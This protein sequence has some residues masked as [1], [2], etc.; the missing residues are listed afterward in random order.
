VRQTRKRRGG[1][2]VETIFWLGVALRLALTVVNREANDPHVEVSRIIADE[3]RV[4]EIGEVWEAFQPKLYHLLVAGAWWVLSLRSSSA[5]IVAAQMVSCVAGIVVLVVVRR[6]L[7]EIDIGT[8]ARLVTFALVALNPGL[9]AIGAQATN[10]ALAIA[11][12]TLTLYFGYRVFMMDGRWR[13]FWAMTS[14]ASL[15]AITKGHGLVLLGA[16]PAAF[17]FSALTLG[18]DARRQ[19]RRA[20]LFS[21][22]VLATAIVAGPY[23]ELHRH[24][25]SPLGDPVSVR[26][27]F[28]NLLEKTVAGRPG[29]RS[30]FEALATFRFVDLL[31]RPV[32]TNGNELI[33]QSRTS[34]WSQLYA[35]AHFAHFA[36]YPPSWEDRRTGIQQLGR[37]IF[38]LGLM[39][40][41]IGLAGLVRQ[42]RGLIASVARVAGRGKGGAPR[43]HGREAITSPQ[44]LLL[45][46][47]WGYLATVTL[48]A[49]KVR[50][51][52]AMKEIFVYPGL[53][54]FTMCF[55]LELNRIDLRLHG[56]VVARGIA[57]AVFGGLAFCYV[58]DI[59]ALIARLV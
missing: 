23:R 29:V 3:G 15:A 39:P 19:A 47:A 12:S 22:L 4:P 6:F 32:M 34:L 40:T 16:V 54:G 28:P 36:A 37:M 53:L 10:D 7:A 13:D 50:D 27:P 24:F 5:R 59:G 48:Y 56:Y 44:A 43:D 2:G 17:A 18:A 26:M 58:A 55:A 57:L 45:L 30:I 33:E 41:A 14:A 49:L 8:P 42:S 51:F 1:S 35:R 9:I 20:A 38:L 46:G 11:L 31:R 52:S 25:G 21:T